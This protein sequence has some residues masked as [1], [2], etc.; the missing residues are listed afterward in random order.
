[1]L[2]A[3]PFGNI[4]R[5]YKLQGSGETSLSC[6]ANAICYTTEGLQ[7]VTRD[8]ASAA[9]GEQGACLEG[10]NRLT[11]RGWREAKGASNRQR[12]QPSWKSC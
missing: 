12:I 2:A 8:S 9:T 3:S 5:A 11:Q 4:A 10:A 1:M 6:Y 7:S